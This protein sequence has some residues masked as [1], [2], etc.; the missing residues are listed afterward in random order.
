MSSAITFLLSFS[1]IAVLIVP[2]CGGIIA[3]IRVRDDYYI[4]TMRILG[5][6]FLITAGGLAII[7]AVGALIRGEQPIWPYL[8]MTGLPAAAVA[9]IMQPM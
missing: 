7:G 6:M 5:T 8:V 3:L 1:A 2:M 9:K 4:K